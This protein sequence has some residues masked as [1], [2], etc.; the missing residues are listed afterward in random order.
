MQQNN[1][2]FKKLT[3]NSLSKNNIEGHKILGPIL[4]QAKKD[5]LKDK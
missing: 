2:S 5:L 3:N 1:S 4:K